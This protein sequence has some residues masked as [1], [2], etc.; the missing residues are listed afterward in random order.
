[1]II[2]AKDYHKAI[3]CR[4]TNLFLKRKGTGKIRNTSD[5]GKDKVGL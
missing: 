3:V 2:S 5:K 4:L 1:M